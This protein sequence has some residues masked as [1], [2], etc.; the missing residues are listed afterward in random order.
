MNAWNSHKAVVMIRQTMN[1]IGKVWDPK[2]EPN[3]QWDHSIH[4]ICKRRDMPALERALK[5][6]EQAET[7]RAEKHRSKTA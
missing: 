1:R 7:A 2:L 5:Y 4:Q 6:W 3:Y